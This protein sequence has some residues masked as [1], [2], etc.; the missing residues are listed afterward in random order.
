MIKITKL[1][2]IMKFFK[3]EGVQIL[4]YTF[5]ILI[6]DYWYS[7]LS[8]TC[9]PALSERVLHSTPNASFNLRT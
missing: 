6:L 7:N 8:R 5:I 3:S 1:N 2:C 4:G 9:R